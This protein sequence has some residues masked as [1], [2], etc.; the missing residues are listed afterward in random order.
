MADYLLKLPYPLSW[1]PI[2]KPRRAPSLD[3]G[4]S[5]ATEK[6]LKHS[7]VLFWQLANSNCRS[8]MEVSDG[9]SG[10]ERTLRLVTDSAFPRHLQ[11]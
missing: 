11:P 9:G 2:C 8:L 1:L 10:G 5:E 7:K 3:K 4:G 6:E